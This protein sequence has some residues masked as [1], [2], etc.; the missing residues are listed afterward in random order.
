MF[1][2]CRGVAEHARRACAPEADDRT[3][4]EGEEGAVAAAAA[5]A[6]ERTRRR[7]HVHETETEVAREILQGES[8]FACGPI[9]ARPNFPHI[10]FRNALA[11][12]W[13]PKTATLPTA[14]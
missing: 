14:A 1:S 5:D 6:N 9:H 4:R 12:P 3:G 2:N 8:A 7:G 10:L 11:L 13:P